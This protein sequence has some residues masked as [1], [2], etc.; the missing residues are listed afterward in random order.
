MI[1]PDF[2]ATEVPDLQGAIKTY[3]SSNH[4]ITQTAPHGK[5]LTH[6]FIGDALFKDL[7]PEFARCAHVRKEMAGAIYHRSD[8]DQ[9]RK[10]RDL[11]LE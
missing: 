5:L 1:S 4:G 3:I 6:S 9:L 11:Y 10:F 7:E 2:R 8:P